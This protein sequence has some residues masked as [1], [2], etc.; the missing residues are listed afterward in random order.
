MNLLLHN[1]LKDLRAVRGP[2]GLWLGVL[3]ADCT[4]QALRLDRFIPPEHVDSV[5]SAAV[6]VG[7]AVVA[8]GWVLAAMVVQADALDSPS[9]FWLTRPLSPGALL[10]GKLLVILPLFLLL[11]VA[12]ATIVVAANGVR[13][14]LLVRFAL[15]RL[16]VDSALLMPVLLAASV[17]HNLARMI[18][19]LTVG[20]LIY[21][22]VHSLAVMQWLLLPGLAPGRDYALVRSSAVLVAMALSVVGSLALITHQYLTR[23]TRR[24]LWLGAVSLAFVVSVGDFWPWNLLP[25][26]LPARVDTAVFDPTGVRLSLD[27]D[28]LRRGDARPGGA[29]VVSAG[30]RGR[31]VQGSPQIDTRGFLRAD[32]VPPGWV[33]RVLK[34]TGETRLGGRTI[35]S[36]PYGVYSGETPYERQ[37]PGAG[38]SGDV[39]LAFEQAL[40]ARI[41]NNARVIEGIS[42]HLF[43]LD[44]A[45]FQAEQ[46]VRGSLRATLVMEAQRV[47]AGAPIPLVPGASGQVDGEG[48]TVIDA[49]RDPNGRL[50]TVRLARAQVRTA[51]EPRT[52]LLLRN[53]RTGEAFFPWPEKGGTGPFGLLPNDMRVAR[54]ELALPGTTV[55]IDARWLADAEL[56]I[57]VIETLGTFEKAL[58]LE[59]FVLPRMSSYK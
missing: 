12:A 21:A 9:A 44:E 27:A 51:G 57:A 25:D 3:L 4:A 45:V 23:S 46:G 7:L 5:W 33:V 56:V 52:H 28:G 59:G 14:P 43:H 50:L 53:R 32:G 35:T 31:V 1:A 15:E 18:L 20:G 6:A 39:K 10:A 11:P 26:P 42:V 38:L 55:P 22:T 41:V 2:L 54:R 48:V 34:G 29:R 30:D 19:V 13:G 47:V 49:P 24:T 40:R 8:F 36:A 37:G 58:T 17:A 16:A